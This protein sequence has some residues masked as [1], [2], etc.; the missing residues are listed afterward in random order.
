MSFQKAY[1]SL[2][3]LSKP[4][5]SRKLDIHRK[6]G[7]EEIQHVESCGY[8]IAFRW[9]TS[10][11]ECRICINC[12]PWHLTAILLHSPVSRSTMRDNR[13]I[14]RDWTHCVGGMRSYSTAFGPTVL[15]SMIFFTPLLLF[16]CSTCQ[17]FSACNGIHYL[18]LFSEYFKLKLVVAIYQEIEYRL[19]QAQ[20]QT[21]VS[22]RA[23][24]IS[25]SLSNF[26]PR[27]V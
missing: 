18:T 27:N 26:M 17:V 11:P 19:L 10:R 4:R 24:P 13:L 8:T 7:A 3:D 23:L 16:C 25:F 6:V 12:L 21:P 20:L 5:I 22:N 9:Q 15:V 14:Q 2:T 1:L